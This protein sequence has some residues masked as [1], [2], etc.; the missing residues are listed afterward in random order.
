M[1]EFRETIAYN[2]KNRR[3]LRQR[4]LAEQLSQL[5]PVGILISSDHVKS[6]ELANVF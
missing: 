4:R 3:N 6:H 1:G 5:N 2:G